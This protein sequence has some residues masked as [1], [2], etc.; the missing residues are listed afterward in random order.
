MG[1]KG[2]P[3][4]DVHGRV[5]LANGHTLEGLYAVG[6]AAA[7]VM[8]PGYPGAGATIGASMTFGFVA[9]QHAARRAE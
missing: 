7:S 2:G 3:K 5:L 4:T 1:T 8:G 9:A 6:N